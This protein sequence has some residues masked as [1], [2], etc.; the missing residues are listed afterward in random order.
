VDV[1]KELKAQPDKLETFFS[2]F[3]AFSFVI[4]GPLVLYYYQHFSF[5]GFI[6]AC[7]SLSMALFSFC[8]LDSNKSLFYW[9]SV[10]MVFLSFFILN[11]I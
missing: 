2:L 3:L 4:G 10:V 7:I 5:G 9:F 11:Y 1:K 6:L 8:C